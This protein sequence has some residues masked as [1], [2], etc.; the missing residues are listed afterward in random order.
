MDFSRQYELCERRTTFAGG[1]TDAVLIEH[2]RSMGFASASPDEL[3][4]LRSS[5]A[6][7]VARFEETLASLRSGSERRDR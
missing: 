5:H 3:H 4:R 1:D 2:L 7:F 6:Q